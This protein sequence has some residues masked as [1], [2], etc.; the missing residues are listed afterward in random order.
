MKQSA[1]SSPNRMTAPR[2][3]DKAS[4]LPITRPTVY[5]A[6]TQQIVLSLLKSRIA[7][8]PSPQN[9]NVPLLWPFPP[10]NP[11]SVHEA[12]LEHDVIP[13]SSA[14]LISKCVAH[15][16]CAISA[17][18][19]PAWDMIKAL[20]GKVPERSW[21]KGE[22]SLTPTS[23]AEAFLPALVPIRVALDPLTYCLGS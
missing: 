1:T 16:V 14:R 22:T 19:L 15:P 7:G 23:T 9:V 18:E 20:P 11:N 4:T 3:V 5:P 6:V 10:V 8:T 2:P 13:C 12:D 21:V 17:T